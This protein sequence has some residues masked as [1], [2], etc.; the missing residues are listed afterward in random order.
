MKDIGLADVEKQAAQCDRWQFNS[1]SLTI[2]GK[3]YN[4]YT[5]ATAST[6]AEGLTAEVVY[7]NK[8]TRQDY[9]GLDVTGKIVLLDIDQRNDW[10]ITY[11]MLEAMHQGA[12]GRAC[13]QRRQALPRSPMMR[14]TARTSAALWASPPCPSA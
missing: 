13:G 14:S 9:E 4:V 12:V 7:V 2:D 8:G 6:P 5:Y 10:W 11:P 1:A 3:D